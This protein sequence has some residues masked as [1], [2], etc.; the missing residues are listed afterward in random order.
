MRIRSTKPEFWRSSTMAEFDM[1]DRL[2]LKAL[3]S[4]VDDNG[5]GRD[6]VVIICADAFPHDLAKSPEIVAKVSGALQRFAEADII[7]RYTVGGE[8]LVYVRWWKRWQYIDKPKAGRYP[9][10]DGTMNYREVVDETIGAGQAITVMP[11]REVSPKPRENRA[12]TSRKPAAKGPQIQSGEQGNRGTGGGGA[13]YVGAE[14]HPGDDPEPP[15][16][17]PDHPN[18]TD[19]PCIPCKRTGAIHKAWV[20]AAPQRE[21]DRAKAAKALRDNCPRCKGTNTYED[22]DGVHLCRPHLVPEATARA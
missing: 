15:R 10:P 2:I 5:V 6:N 16:Y 21:A 13:D 8:P 19:K 7:V 1:E 11:V 4:Y 20:D 18:D 12:K 17:C 9:R 22:E 3:E 14:G